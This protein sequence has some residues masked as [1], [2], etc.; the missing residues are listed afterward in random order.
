VLNNQAKMKKSTFLIVVIFLLAGCSVTS[1][2][3]FITRSM[4]SA[5]QQA[6]LM[7]EYMSQYP[8]MLPRTYDQDLDSLFIV[9]SQ[10]WVSG[11]FPGSLW[12]LYD[13][14]N[15]EKLKKNAVSFLSRVEEE[16][17]NTYDHD[18]GF[19]IYCSFGNAFRLT[20]DFAY[21]DVI[22]TAAQSAT[23]RFNTK[24]GLIRSWDFG[25]EK[26]QYPVIIDNLM[27]LELLMKAFHLTGDSLYYHVAVTHADNTM[28]NHFRPDYSSY[29]VVSYDTITA[30]P[31]VKMTH[32]GAFD[33][34]H[35]ARGQAW[36]LYGYTMMY[37]ETGKKKYLTLAINIA[38]FIINHPNMP[39]DMIP[40][41]DLLSADIPETYRDASAA[42]IM[43]SA[44]IELSAYV[45][46]ELQT[47][48]LRVAETQLKTLSSPE[49]LAE[50]GS[51]GFFILKRSVGNLPRGHEVDVPLSYA[52][53]YFLEALI[54]FSK[55]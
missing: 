51:N 47:N 22:L 39:K 2:D 30:L 43:A 41:W 11:F 32:Q 1:K 12:Y 38:N 9:N 26:W 46:S 52:D 10:H 25:R 34:S 15:D 21:Q 13:F 27:N 54:R 40:Y 42:A 16:K 48:Y 36:G 20:E 37:R 4:N 28:K 50:P 17:Y 3:D 55:L 18:I 35:W 8:G 23:K 53:Y 49:Y 5:R 44:L 29:H 19:Q 45:T 14:Y 31:H 7:A 24:I 6:L 33:E